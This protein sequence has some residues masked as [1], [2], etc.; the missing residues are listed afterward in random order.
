M[1]ADSRWYPGSGIYRHVW[2][3]VTG[4]LHIAPWGVYV[5]TPV[6]GENEALVSVETRVVNQT[7]AE[8]RATEP[9][10]TV[11]SS[12][13]NER[14]EEV[15]SVKSEETVTPLKD[16]TYAQQ[17]AVA[18]PALWSPEQPHLYTLVSRVLPGRQTGGRTAHF[19]RHTEFLFQSGQGV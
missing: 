18:H 12:V 2:L 5:T 9:R 4:P 8:A 13:V 6:V 10:A 15:A 17:V 3:N 7:P 1:I 16:R 11:V 14:G 19:V